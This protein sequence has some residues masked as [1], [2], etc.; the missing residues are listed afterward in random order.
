MQLVFL[1]TSGYHNTQRRETT[2]LMLPELGVVLDAGSGFARVRDWLATN[3]LDVFLT[4]AHL[5]HCLGLT[6]LFTVL[7]GKEVTRTTVHG[8]ASKLQ[9]IREH[10]F[11][12]DLFPVMPPLSWEA[13][14]DSPLTLASGAKLTWW[15]MEHPGGSLGYRIEWRERSLAFVTDTLADPAA[16]Y[17]EHLRGVDLLVH[18]C[19]FPDEHIELAEKSGHSCISA[20]AQVAKAAGVGR[21]ILTHVEPTV[22]REGLLDVGVAR[23]IFPRT[24]LAEDGMVVEV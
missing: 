9:S 18:E 10:L 8:E 3:E 11:H 4:H 20:V 19:T 1:G 13:L 14:S 12:P 22:E 17:V 15:P 6:F 23:A 2:C 7:Y 5:D 21:L 24:E 16:K